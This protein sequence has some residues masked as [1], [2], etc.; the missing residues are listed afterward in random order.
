MPA[1]FRCDRSNHIGERGL[2]RRV[3]AGVIKAKKGSE[4]QQQLLPLVLTK[5]SFFIVF[6]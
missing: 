4:I 5:H 6:Q 2:K 3:E 1:D